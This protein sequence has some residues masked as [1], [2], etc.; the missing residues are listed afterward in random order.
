MSTVGQT[1]RVITVG[2]TG[3]IGSGKSTVA[4]LLSS[5]GAVIIDADVLAR[6]AVAPGTPG[7]ALVIDEFGPEVLAPDGSLDRARLGAVVFADPDRLAALN[8]IIHPFVR[9]RSH[10][11]EGAAADG[12]VVVHVIPLL[13]ENGLTGFDVVVVVDASE[14]TQ[15]RRLAGRGMD[16]ADARA[17]IDAQATR[18]QRR[19][20]ADVVIDNDGD[21]A[22]LQAQVG[23][24]W[25]DL[26]RRNAADGDE[27]V[28]GPTY[29]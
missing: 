3:G 10:E 9:T 11:L 1:D 27:P 13:V 5:Y 6:E 28:G 12:D 25:A 22:G 15:L 20:A 14:E 4:E 26:R 19:A 21:P 17:R 7:L 8:A 29:G 18:E 23:R 16:E 24:L 2:L